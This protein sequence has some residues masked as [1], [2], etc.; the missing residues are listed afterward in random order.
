L[1][2]LNLY[3]TPGTEAA[4]TSPPAG[5]E[6]SSDRSRFAPPVTADRVHISAVANSG[7]AE[8]QIVVT[9]VVDPGYH[10][11]ANPA[12]F[13]YL[14]PTSVQFSQLHPMRVNYPEATRFKAEFAARELDVYEGSVQLRATF[15]P[16]MLGTS[17]AI[18]GVV[19]AQACD[20]KV[21]L[22]PS[23][24]AF[25]ATAGGPGPPSTAREWGG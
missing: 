25:G 17:G 10:I 22:A 9:V 11:N 19:I 16:H 5:P 2:S 7:T 23:R 14:I 18:Q 3:P 21:C 20:L 1:V 6:P 13:D 15:P 24:I 4:Q 12:S 8:D